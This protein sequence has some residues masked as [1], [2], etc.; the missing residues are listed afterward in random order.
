LVIAAEIYTL[1]V[2]ADGKGSLVLRKMELKQL[3]NPRH[4]VKLTQIDLPVAEL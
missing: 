3:S 4:V 2:A 1:D